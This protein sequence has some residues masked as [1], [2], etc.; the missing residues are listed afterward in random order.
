MGVFREPARAPGTLSNCYEAI[1]ECASA[2]ASWVGR[3]ASATGTFISESAHKVAEF[4]KPYFE[5][6]KNFAK[7]N[8]E[9]LILGTIFF[10][11]GAIATAIIANIFCKNTTPVP[12]PPPPPPVVTP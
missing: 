8:K 9:S 12:V 1:K 4:V 10:V 6:V 11:I 2:T 5:N 3:T 7:D